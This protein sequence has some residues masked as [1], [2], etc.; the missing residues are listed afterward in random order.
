MVGLS[1]TLCS[2]TISK[3]KCFSSVCF[4]NFALKIERLSKVIIFYQ[5]METQR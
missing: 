4:Y 2:D 1:C 3:E 5:E